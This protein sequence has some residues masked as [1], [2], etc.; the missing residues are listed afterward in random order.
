MMKIIVEM[1]E[2]E[3]LFFQSIVPDLAMKICGLVAAYLVAHL[4]GKWG[5]TLD[6][7]KLTLALFSLWEYVRARWH[8][9][10]VTWLPIFAALLLSSQARAVSLDL[11]KSSN[12][13][14]AVVMRDVLDHVWASGVSKPIVFLDTPAGELFELDAL[15]TADVT[16]GNPT[17]GLVFSLPVGDLAGL[18]NGL[19]YIG[20]PTISARAGAAAPGWAAV[21][22]HALAL[23]IGGGYDA[24]PKG[25]ERPWQF[26][27][28]ARV[29]IPL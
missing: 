10:S 12:D 17:A 8:L 15:A 9:K 6:P 3:I 1:T 23:D 5:V 22:G 19:L 14:S 18:L 29:K 4:S 21:I 13:V 11:D 26:D 27:V 24:L 25:G 20:Q 28:G 2:K 16:K 7:Q